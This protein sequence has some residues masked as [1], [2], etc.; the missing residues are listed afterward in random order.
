M[1]NYEKYFGTPEKAAETMSRIGNA[2]CDK[3][4]KCQCDEA[5]ISNPCPLAGL[6][7]CGWGQFRDFD[8]ASVEWMNEEA[9]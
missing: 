7:L 1:T 8:M 9:E 5:G 4:F 3:W 2:L 6:G